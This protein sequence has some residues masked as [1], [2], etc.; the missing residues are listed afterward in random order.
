MVAAAAQARLPTH[1][2]SIDGRGDHCPRSEAS[3]SR[4]TMVRRLAT[5]SQVVW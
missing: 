4:A 1:A 3:E 2:R 5:S